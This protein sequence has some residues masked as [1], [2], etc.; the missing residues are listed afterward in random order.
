MGL[1]LSLHIHLMEMAPTFMPFPPL[2]N[3]LYIQMHVKNME[4]PVIKGGHILSIMSVW[5]ES[6][7]GNSKK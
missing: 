7:H 4:I 6:G 3:L 1:S 5:A 2:L